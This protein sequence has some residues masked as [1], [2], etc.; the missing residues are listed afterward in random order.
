MV[1]SALD[2][3]K[4]SNVTPVAAAETVFEVSLVGDERLWRVLAAKAI[5]NAG[6][7]STTA[8]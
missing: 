3:Y 1:S 8:T 5:F 2:V 4:P 7:E 6:V